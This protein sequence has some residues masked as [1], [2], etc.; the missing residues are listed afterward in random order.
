MAQ[1]GDRQQVTGLVDGCNLDIYTETEQLSAALSDNS[2]I[3]PSWGSVLSTPSTKPHLNS[4]AERSKGLQI[5]DQSWKLASKIFS[6]ADI[7]CD[8]ILLGDTEE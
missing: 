4:A 7:P 3:P 6:P 8:L 1:Q 5:C 2:D